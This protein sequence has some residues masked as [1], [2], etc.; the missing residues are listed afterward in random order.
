[1]AECQVIC[2]DPSRV[3]E[4]WPH[5]A[6]FI[7]AA[8]ERGDLTTYESLRASVFER[9]SLLWLACCGHNIEAAAITELMRSAKSKV[10]I[11]TACGGVDMKRWLPLLEKIEDFAQDEGCDCVRIFGRRG[12]KRLLKHYTENKI[13][14]ERR[15]T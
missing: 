12:W 13:V 3:S 9:G 5:V 14:L 1:L 11:V 10:C 15:L 4:V 6:H 7:K 2:V 8:A